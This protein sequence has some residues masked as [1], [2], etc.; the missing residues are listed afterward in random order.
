[1]DDALRHPQRYRGGEQ[2]VLGG[3][4]PQVADPQIYVPDLRKRYVREFIGE[5]L[6]FV[7][8]ARFAGYRNPADISPKIEKVASAH[9]ALLMVLCVAAQNTNVGDKDVDAAFSSVRGLVPPDCETK[10]IGTPNKGYTDGLFDLGACLDKI[11]RATTPDDKEANRK[12][13]RDQADAAQAAVRRLVAQNAG[14]DQVDSAVQAL[15][16]APINAPTL[17]AQLKAP[18]PPPPP[19]AGDLCDALKAL[20]ARL[21]FSRDASGEAT[22]PDFVQI[23]GPDGLI[24]KHKPDPAGNPKPNPRFVSFYNH[25]ADIQ[26][27]LYPNGKDLRLSYRIGVVSQEKVPSFSLTTGGTALTPTTGPKY[28][29]WT[30]NPQETVS[31]SVPQYP[32]ISEAGTWAIFKFLG[33]YAEPGQLAPSSYT[34]AI[35]ITVGIPTQ[36]SPRLKLSLDAGAATELFASGHL[37]SLSCVTKVTQ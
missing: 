33:K 22:L 9:S 27:A 37:A 32:P 12:Q 8:A 29:V 19:G 34:F 6:S 26:H 24:V 28:F 25:I 35:P 3:E 20:A 10:V 16:S 18:P 1:M 2:W 4:T 31:L 7:K 11:G 23:F 21:P 30:G 13:C 5:W 17:Q 36:S 14:L 15:L